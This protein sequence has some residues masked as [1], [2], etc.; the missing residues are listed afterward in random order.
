MRFVLAYHRQIGDIHSLIVEREVELTQEVRAAVMKLRDA[1]QDSG[2]AIGILDAFLCLAHSAKEYRYT[3][4]DI[5]DQDVLILEESRHPIL[6]HRLAASD[7]ATPIIANDVRL[8]DCKG[9]QFT[10]AL[11]IVAPNASGKTMY[12]HQVALNVYLAHIGSFVPATYAE[13]GLTDKILLS[14]LNTSKTNSSKDSSFQLDLKQTWRV[15]LEATER[16]LVLMDEFGSGTIAT[17]GMGLFGAVLVTLCKRNTRLLGATHFHQL[18]DVDLIKEQHSIG[19]LGFYTMS[20]VEM[21]GNI[22]FMYEL[23]P[24]GCRDSLGIY[25]FALLTLT[26]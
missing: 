18:V 21:E 26:L 14:P 3:R 8:G 20:I 2:R 17:D 6:E 9:I 11:L 23:V 7:N 15:V 10:K 5:I 22:E 12:M 16:S 4:P 1:I 13:I 25:W 19:K 24:G